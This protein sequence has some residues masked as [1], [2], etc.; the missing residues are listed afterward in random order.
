MR[1][2]NANGMMTLSKEDSDQLWRAVQERKAPNSFS[3]RAI[4][5][6]SLYP[7]RKPTPTRP[8]HG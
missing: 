5:L 2:G 1:Y 7:T 3:V 6:P 8:T 4:P